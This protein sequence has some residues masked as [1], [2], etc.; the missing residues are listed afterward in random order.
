M[1][2]GGKWPYSCFVECCFQDL[3][4]ITCSILV[5]SPSSFFS[6]HFVSIHVVHPYSSID[7][8][9]AWKKYYFIL[10]DR[11]NFHIIN[12]LLI[13]VHAFARRILTSLSVDEILLSRYVNLSTN[14]RGLLFR[15]KMA[16]S[17]LKY[18]YSV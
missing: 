8:T 3:F 1:E 14:F 2:M 15:A 6:M 16:P 9:A 5:Q 18:M 11:S 4:N 17:H 13:A 12:K 10:S 7:T